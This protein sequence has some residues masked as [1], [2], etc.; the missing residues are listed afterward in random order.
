MP[1]YPVRLIEVGSLLRFVVDQF[2]KTEEDIVQM[3]KYGDDGRSSTMLA[4]LKVGVRRSAQAYCCVSLPPALLLL[5]TLPRF[6]VID[7]FPP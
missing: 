1:G 6:A 3:V 7:S 4:E 2:R 5:P